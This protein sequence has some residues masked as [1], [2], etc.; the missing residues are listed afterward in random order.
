MNVRVISW[1][2][3]LSLLLVA[4][5]M[6]VS[7]LV[8]CFSEGDDSAA[9]LFYS[10][11]VTGVTG[12]YPLLFVRRK[13]H[14]LSAR[15]G[16]C[17]VVFS[18]LAACVFGSIPFLLHGEIIS[19]VDALFESVSGFTTTG[20]SILV[21][22]ESLPAG[23]QFWRI[24]TAWVGGVG[25]V[26]LFSMIAVRD[27]DKSVLYGSEISS[28]ARRDFKGARNK[29][30]SRMFLI[31]IAMTAVSMIALKLTGMTW[32]E[33]ATCA[34]S[35]CSTCGFCVKNESIAFWDNP[36]AEIILI[37]TMLAA[38]I[39]FVLIYMSCIRRSYKHIFKSEVSRTFI[40]L[41]LIAIATIN[42]DLVLHGAP[43]AWKT[44]RQ[45]AFQVVSISTTTGFAT[46]DTTTWPS[47]S[48]VILIVCSLICGCS[49]STS[50]GMKMDRLLLA[51]KGFKARIDSAS[52]PGRV[53]PVKIDGKIRPDN[54]I[55]DA[56]VF[57]FSYF[58]LIFIFG[59]VNI[60][61]GLDV[62]TGLTASVACIGNVGPGFGEIGSMSSYANIPTM[63]K[64]TSMIE[65][66]LGRLEIFPVFYLLSSL[67]DK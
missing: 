32:L 5:L 56:F 55:N 53:I 64:I 67:R 61:G 34:M 26:T 13:E 45:A 7:G 9:L 33:A 29:F 49:G 37:I 25:I 16:N 11:L 30:A 17:V 24:S 47:L 27:D 36:A 39:N 46:V 62:T 66:I 63:V 10:A 1:Y 54:L 43:L 20:A 57:M 48:M 59:L 35:A 3:G 23:L 6:V 60:A 38:G 44:L 18:W 22:I 52:H 42:L 41:V 4:A 51:I 28:V 14:H 65:M 40:V 12:G 58:L 2:V 50:G 21:D 15:E 8:A 19:L 31:Y